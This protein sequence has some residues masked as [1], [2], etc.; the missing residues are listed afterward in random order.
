MFGFIILVAL[1]VLILIT[2]FVFSISYLIGGKDKKKISIG[3]LIPILVLL[4][5][6]IHYQ[7]YLG[8]WSQQ[9]AYNIMRQI[10]TEYYGILVGMFVSIIILLP[11]AL[12]KKVFSRK[13]LDVQSAETEQNSA[14]MDPSRRAFFKK[15]TIAIPAISVV[16]GAGLA[17][18]SLGAPEIN[19]LELKYKN[20]PNYLKNYKILQLSDIHIGPFYDMKDFAAD[21]ERVKAEKP[22]RVVI[23]GDL[24]DNISY[25]PELGKQLDQL[26]D[27]I[28]DGIDYILGNHEYRHLDTLIPFVQSL[29]MRFLRNEALL[30][31][32][33]TQHP[34]YLVGVEYPLQDTKKEREEFLAKALGS[35]PSNAFIIL[36][37]HHPM[38]IE[39]AFERNIP[40]TL[41]G[42]THGG[43][44]NL[45]G[46]S[47]L[48]MPWDFW[49]GLY[50]INNNYGYVSTGTGHWFP[51]RFNCPREIAVFSFTAY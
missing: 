44:F 51:V 28:P 42:H 23:T 34:V 26:Y 27:E 29:K 1:V 47:L 11:L 31:G 39:E 10:S 35:V 9:L 7:V 25:L 36:L 46:V 32:N 48:P 24:I 16:G 13:S 17:S 20:L 30:I 33:D 8:W 3:L 37:A 21:L 41:T 6:T 38:F 2:L 15:A 40:L 14:P 43:Q 50:E 22:N 45:L 4:S 19:H 18:T 12:I 5:I 49:R